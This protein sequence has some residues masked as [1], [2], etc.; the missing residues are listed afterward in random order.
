MDKNSQG[1]KHWAAQLKS[2]MPKEHLVNHFR[3]VALEHNAKSSVPSLEQL[4]NSEDS[5]KRIGVVIP[6]SESD[7]FLVNSLMQNLKK[8][9]KDFNIYVFTQ[10]QYYPYIEDNPA[11]HKCLPYSPQL[12]N[13]LAMEG[14][15]PHK[16]FFEMVFH[17]HTTTQ[18]N[19]SFVHNGIN[20]HQFSLI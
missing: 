16:G 10:P 13:V 15:G 1:L 11:V 18:K 12:E 17:P 5:G 20:K 6:Q 3:Q 19:L 14:G 7:V 9:Y 4:L 8:Q 2:G